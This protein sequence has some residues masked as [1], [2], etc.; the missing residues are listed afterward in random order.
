MPP[1]KLLTEKTILILPHEHFIVET[2]QVDKVLNGESEEFIVAEQKLRKYAI[3]GAMKTSDIHNSLNLP[4]SFRPLLW[5]LKWEDVDIQKDK[6]DI[7]LAAINEGALE[8]WRWVIKTYGREVIRE[9]LMKRLATEF[10]P[11]SRNLAQV[12]FDVPAFSHAR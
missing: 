9:I 10:H 11:E 4:E 5:S 12:I 3:I 8:H 7:I 1:F 6:A 2:A